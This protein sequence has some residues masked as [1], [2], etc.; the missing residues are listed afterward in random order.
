M[1]AVTRQPAVRGQAEA[2]SRLAAQAPEPNRLHSVLFGTQNRTSD[3][4]RLRHAWRE[5]DAAVVALHP[6]A[7]RVPAH[8]VLQRRPRVGGLESGHVGQQDLACHAR[9]RHLPQPALLCRQRRQTSNM[10]TWACMPTFP[11]RLGTRSQGRDLLNSGP[12]F[13]FQCA[14]SSS[15]HPPAACTPPPLARWGGPSCQEQRAAVEGPNRG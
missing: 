8:K 9:A 5:A 6:V 3:P 15:S 14:S 1:A 10:Y 4:H 11:R 7:R 2:Q 12:G 13:G